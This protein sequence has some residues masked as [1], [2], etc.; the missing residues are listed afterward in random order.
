MNKAKTAQANSKQS[1]KPQKAKLC[2]GITDTRERE[3]NEKL[4]NLKLE[5][6]TVAIQSDFAWF[7]SPSTPV[8]NTELAKYVH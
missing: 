7:W 2:E 6:N 8:G 1:T 5:T 4:R 3:Q